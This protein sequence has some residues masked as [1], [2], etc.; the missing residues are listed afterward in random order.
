MAELPEAFLAHRVVVE[1]LAG[2]GAYGERFQEPVEVPAW[3]EEKR[4]LARNPDGT[5]TV[6]EAT[7]RTLLEYAAHFPPGS[8][9]TIHTELGGVPLRRSR[10]I[11]TAYHTDGG[12]GGWQHLEVTV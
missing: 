6:S 2:A 8:Y 4:R 3:V 10:L 11:S 9:V 7:I 12:L 5:E 1:P